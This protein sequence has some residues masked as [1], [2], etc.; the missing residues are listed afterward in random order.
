MTRLVG[1]PFND[2]FDFTRPVTAPVRGADG[3]L[4]IAAIDAPRFDHDEDGVR[5]GLLVGFLDT[6]GQ[7]DRCAVVAGDWEIEGAGTVLH[8]YAD[9]ADTIVRRAFYTDSVRAM[10]NAVLR[11]DGH[12]RIIGAVPG[13]LRN[14]GGFVRY[15]ERDWDLAAKLGTGVEGEQ[16]GDG[17]GELDGGD[18]GLVEA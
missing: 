12:H 16:L 4:A 9:A 2:T 1:Y 7:S 3:E 17:S 8:E 11:V 10:V 15:R 18:R 13:H 14:R 5:T 6:L